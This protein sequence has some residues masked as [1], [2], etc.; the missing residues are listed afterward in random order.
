MPWVLKRIWFCSHSW[1]VFL[2]LTQI[3]MIL[4]LVGKQSKEAISILTSIYIVFVPLIIYL[5]KGRCRSNHYFFYRAPSSPKLP[6]VDQNYKRFQ[7][8]Q[9]QGYSNLTGFCRLIFIKCSKIFQNIPPYSKIFQNIL[10]FTTYFA[11]YFV[12]QNADYDSSGLL[13]NNQ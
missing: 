2:F 5:K 9:I 8:F 10:W 13:R 4:I 7:T 12:V 3:N 11:A 6:W 1:R